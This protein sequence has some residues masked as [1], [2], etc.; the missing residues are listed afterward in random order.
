MKRHAMPH[1][2]TRISALFPKLT[3]HVLAA[4]GALSLVACGAVTD[5]APGP[6]PQGVDI[7]GA[8]LGGEF[9]LT[10]SDGEPVSW[11]DFAGQYRIIYFGF[12]F[13]P[14]ICPTDLS[15]I[16]AGLRA[17]EEQSPDRAARIQPIFVTV[18][19]ERDTPEVVGEFA[20][21]FHPRL[22]GLTG[23]PEQVTAVME[24]YGSSAQK[25]PVGDDGNYTMQHTSFAFLFGPEGEPLGIIPTD[26]DGA[27]IAAE[28]AGWVR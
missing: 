20:A 22:I 23:A 21:N 11:S 8:D 26:G 13:C 6:S 24:Q 14:D 19:P 17:F 12:T 1:Y 27:S 3:R 16:G 2:R 7:R 28:L 15:R 4:L 5:S 9:T 18:D 25:I 10:G